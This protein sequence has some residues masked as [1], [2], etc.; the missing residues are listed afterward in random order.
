MPLP[1]QAK[2]LRASGRRSRSSGAT[3]PVKVDVRIIACANRDLPRSRRRPLPRRPV[4]RLNV[5]PLMLRP[6]RERP[7]DI[8]PLAFA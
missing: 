6:L 5:F 7:D 3:Q 1:L 2:L 4:Y 8:A